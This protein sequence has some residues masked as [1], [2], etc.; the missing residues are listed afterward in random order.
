MLQ[1]SVYVNPE[2][3]TDDLVAD[4]LGLAENRPAAVEVVRQIYTNDGGPLPF[5]AAAALPDA[6]PLLVVWGD[7]DNLAP[8]QYSPVGRFFR[9]RAEK[10][11]AMRFEELASGHVPQDD[12]PEVTNRILGDWLATVN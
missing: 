3:V 10:L 9:A 1:A 5:T 12:A 7:R 6:F 2:R 4:Y 8:L 11:P